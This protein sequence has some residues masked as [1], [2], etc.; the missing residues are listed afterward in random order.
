MLFRENSSHSAGGILAD[1]QVIPD[2]KLIANNYSTRFSLI[3]GI[4]LVIG[5]WKDSSSDFTYTEGD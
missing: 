4:P 5:S 3:T 2:L 1:E